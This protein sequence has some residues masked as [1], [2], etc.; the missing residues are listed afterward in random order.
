MP[1]WHRSDQ[2]HPVV[3]ETTGPLAAE[4]AARL[5]E[6][7]LAASEFVMRGHYS[8]ARTAYQELLANS[9]DPSLRSLVANDLGV[10][11][12]LAADNSAAC[13]FF[14]RA[15][16]YDPN[17]V[18]AR[19]NLDC[20]SQVAVT[21]V[22]LPSNASPTIAL[23][24]THPTP[25]V[26]SKSTR[27]VILS[28]LFNW[29]ST[30][31]G[32]IH[33]AEL[34]R[35]LLRAGYEVCHVYACHTDWRLGQVS[36][37]TGVPSIALNF[38]AAQWH[39]AEIRRR[40]HRYFLRLAA[41]ECLCPLN[42][43][44]LLAN[45]GNR[46]DACPKHQLATPTDCRRCVA[47]R[48]HQSGAL[49]RAERT[50][51]GYGT[52]E[53]DSQLRSSIAE[54]AGILVVNPLIATMISPYAKEVYVVPSGFDPDRFPRPQPRGTNFPPPGRKVRLIFAG[55]VE[56]L[57]KGFSVLHEACRQLHAVR[58]DFE[59]V[60]TGDPA[61]QVDAFTRLIGW[62]SQEEL[63]EQLRQA[64]IL[65]FPTV[66][67]EALGRSAVEAMGAGLPVIASR[68]GGLIFTVTDGLTGLL[69]EPGDVADL[70]RQ[71][72][73]LL[74]DVDL[75]HRMGQAGRQRFEREFSW[76][77]ILDRHYRHLLGESR[78]QLPTEGKPQ[79]QPEIRSIVDRRALLAGVTE[80]W[81]LPPRLAEGLWEQFQSFYDQRNYAASLGEFKTFTFEET[82]ILGALFTV[83]RPARVV[84]IGLDDGR[85]TRRIIDLLR[86]LALPDKL[87]GFGDRDS[88]MY[89]DPAEIELQD[90]SAVSEW[91]VNSLENGRGGV[92]IVDCHRREIVLEIL[93]RIR[94]TTAEWSLVLHD[95]GI[96]LCN[97]QMSD[98]SQDRPVSSA[99]GVWQR[100][101][102]AEAFGVADPRSFELHDCRREFDRL[103][104][105]ET[106]HGLGVVL[107][108]PRGGV[109]SNDG[110]IV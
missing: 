97:P 94:Q 83:S 12:A 90:L 53:Y 41:L 54:A 79:F 105:F 18:V 14:H 10:L 110:V 20:L 98:F 11:A 67:E 96:G 72:T 13:E 76:D 88:I 24:S 60:A 4:L 35:F 7:Y 27:V 50:L 25:I 85:A 92:V 84:Q 8:A 39:A 99:T 2:P 56:E 80:L 42:N 26:Q 66:A 44:R 6:A 43:V 61:G 86:F 36:E 19:E 104:I 22:P 15:H 34:G 58:Q 109:F 63:P 37:E 40:F 106:Q 75:R 16:S 55:L 77:V 95:C 102:L 3:P 45:A 9:L 38:T 68:I 64:D 48:Q 31:G 74:D 57:M 52:D 93:S 23:S 87:L 28:L 59:L 21:R 100:H 71:I 30:G 107:K 65:V 33:T 103:R 1:T 73:R 49:H 47:E 32:T 62:Q 5:P 91:D 78:P 108:H 29:P 82:F 46:I 70:M 17:C 51:A 89:V 81:N 101:L 69:F